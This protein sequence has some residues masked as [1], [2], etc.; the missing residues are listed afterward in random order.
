[1]LKNFFF[2]VFFK[3]KMVKCQWWLLEKHTNVISQITFNRTKKERAYSNIYTC[4]LTLFFRFF[5][6]ILYVIR[7]T[8]QSTFV[9]FPL[10]LWFFLF[11][12]FSMKFKKKI[13]C[14]DS[15]SHWISFHLSS[16]HWTRSRVVCTIVEC[17]TRSIRS[18]HL[19]A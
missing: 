4:N 18:T 16:N 15:K 13:R 10:H 9:S 12:F 8:R 7:I 1:M 5:F 19:V 11:R 2:F 6:V 3:S 14:F 17:F